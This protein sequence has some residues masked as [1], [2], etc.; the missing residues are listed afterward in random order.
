MAIRILTKENEPA[1]YVVDWA[2][3]E[4]VIQGAHD[5]AASA[6]IFAFITLKS[7]DGYEFGITV[8]GDW[9]VL[10]YQTADGEPPYMASLGTVMR[11][12][13][14]FTAYAWF[15]HHTEFPGDYAIP[16]DQALKA[17]RQFVDGSR[18]PEAVAWQMV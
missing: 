16:K 15:A 17:A 2:T 18:P 8:G 5:E 6:E 9:S 14:V 7:D 12:S 1:V 11:H 4:S 13:D 10:S 3:A